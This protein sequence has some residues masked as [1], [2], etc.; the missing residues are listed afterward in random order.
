MGPK[1]TGN[2]SCGI[3]L[4]DIDK[5]RG[6]WNSN[7]RSRAKKACGPHRIFQVQIL[8]DYDSQN[9]QKNNSHKDLLTF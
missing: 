4:R 2:F 6:N 9:L 5:C 3:Y 1:L 8:K 7:K